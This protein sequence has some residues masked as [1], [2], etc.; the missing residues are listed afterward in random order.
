MASIPD[1]TILWYGGGR[2]AG[3]GIC[4]QDFEKLLSVFILGVEGS[5]ASREDT[6]RQH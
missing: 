6:E 2:G 3:V 4:M 5:T 1:V